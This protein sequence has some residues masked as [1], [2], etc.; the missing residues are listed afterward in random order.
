MGRDARQ[1]VAIQG[2]LWKP[3]VVEFSEPQQSTEGGLVLLRT[4]DQRLG[5][6]TA[7]ASALRDDRQP[8]KVTHATVDLLL[9]LIHI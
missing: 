9:S 7:M 6:T 4:V 8:G 3:V 2:A 1:S 5:L